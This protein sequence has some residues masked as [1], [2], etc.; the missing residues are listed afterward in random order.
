MP[1]PAGLGI[2]VSPEDIFL[3]SDAFVSYIAGAD[4]GAI[5]CVHASVERD[6][7]ALVAHTP[8]PPKGHERWGLGKFIAHCR[9][10][11]LVPPSLLDEIEILNEHRRTLYH[12][13]HSSADT[14]IMQRASMQIEGE[15]G[16]TV[17]DEFTDVHGRTGDPKEVWEFALRREM[18]A[19]ALASLRTGLALRSWLFEHPGAHC[20]NDGVPGS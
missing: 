9:D 2:A 12:Y 3:L 18:R 1:S 16:R 19:N 8:T 7:A 6:L 11:G 5:F 17:W 4:A 15:D 10:V 13:G 14:A 20:L